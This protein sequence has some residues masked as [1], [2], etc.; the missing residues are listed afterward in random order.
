VDPFANGFG[1]STQ[2]RRILQNN[3]FHIPRLA[4]KRGPLAQLVRTRNRNHPP[5]PK[6]KKFSS[7]SLPVRAVGS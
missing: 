7:P 5:R 6:F 4:G 3:I 2:S 1:H